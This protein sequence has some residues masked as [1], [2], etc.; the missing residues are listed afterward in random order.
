M[1]YV[2][3]SM[4]RGN[5]MTRCV[6]DGRGEVVQLIC[7]PPKQ[8]VRLTDA[9]LPIIAKDIDAG[10][11]RVIE[12]ADAVQFAKVIDSS[13]ESIAILNP[14]LEPV[15]DEPVLPIV[16]E[17]GSDEPLLPAGD[18]IDVAK[19]S[20]RAA[21]AVDSLEAETWSDLQEVTRTEIVGLPDCGEATAD[22]LE[23]GLADR[24]LAFATE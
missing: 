24:G 8:P 3:L 22:E 17:G 7:F 14:M 9:E 20:A 21:K 6:R 11:L 12:E 23:V 18:A 13:G 5:L 16:A 1:T 19:L 2:I 15:S 10:T 4:H